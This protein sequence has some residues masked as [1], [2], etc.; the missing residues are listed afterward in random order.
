MKILLAIL[1]L[2]S[3]IA[4]AAPSEHLKILKT[5]SSSFAWAKSLDNKEESIWP[6]NILSIGHSMQSYQDYSGSPY[7][8][9]GLDIRGAADQKV[10]ASVSGKVVN[11]EN[12]H[13]GNRL[14]WEVAILDD[15]GFVWKYHH[16]EKNSIPKKIKDAF[17][18]ETRIHKGEYIGNIVEWPVSSY[19]EQYHHIHLLVVDGSGRYVNPFLMLPK[20]TDP[21]VPTIENIGIFNSKNKMISGNR[22][23]GSHGLFVE[24]YDLV[25]H[26]EFKLTPYLIAYT[27]DGADEKTVWKFDHLPSMTNDIDY[28]SE[29]YLKKTCGNYRCRE[30]YINLNFNTTAPRAT[31]LFTLSKGQHRVD[32]RVMDFLG[33]SVSKTFNYEVY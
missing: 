16:V 22:V 23:T 1:F 7:W 24:A 10:Y 29:F 31:S 3:S 20:L 30:F 13:P 18:N 4:F 19:G 11:I 8:H 14:Y 21:Q 2:L 28:I 32:V 33:N 25:M 27:L 12:Y 15:S 26:N 17:K 5:K 6:Y 9:D